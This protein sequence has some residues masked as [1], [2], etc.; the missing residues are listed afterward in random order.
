MASSSN[1]TALANLL[2]SVSRS[3]SS[4][5]EQA[6]WQ[7]ASSLGAKALAGVKFVR[8]CDIDPAARKA[9]LMMDAASRPK[10]VLVDVMDPL[11]AKQ[12]L[13][14][15]TMEEMMLEGLDVTYEGHARRKS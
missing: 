7:I 2:D 9:L 10:S 4:A 11:C 8:A 14:L 3:K 6:L 13:E 12:R 1:P 15:Q 5:A